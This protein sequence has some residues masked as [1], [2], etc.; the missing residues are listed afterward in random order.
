MSYESVIFKKEDKLFDKSFSVPNNV[1]S[2]W[3]I[4]KV[5]YNVFSLTHR[6]GDK[7]ATISQMTFYALGMMISMV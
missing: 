7:M 5:I 6:V 3:S 4:L 1:K 2:Y